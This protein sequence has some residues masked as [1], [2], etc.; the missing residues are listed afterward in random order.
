MF[1]QRQIRRTWNVQDRNRTF[2]VRYPDGDDNTDDDC[3]E[4]QIIPTLGNLPQRLRKDEIGI[5]SKTTTLWT[6]IKR[7]V[8]YFKKVNKKQVII[9]KSARLQKWRYRIK[10]NLYTE[11]QRLIIYYLDETWF[12]THNTPFK[13]LC[14]L[15]VLMQNK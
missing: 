4:E 12:N 3:Y 13:K 6:T 15:I 9:V 14:G 8:F 2:H 11:E 10:I 5:K 1:I 7:V